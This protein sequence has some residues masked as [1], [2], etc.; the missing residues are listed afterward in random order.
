M[1]ENIIYLS[2][3][4]VTYS[5]HIVISLSF[6]IKSIVMSVERHWVS[7]IIKK[8]VLKEDIMLLWLMRYILH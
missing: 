5:L 2:I 1:Y 7:L 8:K 4:Y 3:K 6:K